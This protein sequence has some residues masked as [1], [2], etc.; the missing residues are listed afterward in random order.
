[1][2]WGRMDD[3]FDDHPK[4]VAM[5]DRDDPAEAGVAI[6]LWALAFSWVNRNTRKPGKI[7]GLVPAGLPRRWLGAAG[8]PAADLLVEHGLWE[9]HESGGW[10]FHDFGDYLPS[11]S[12]RE[13]RSEAGR[14][15]AEARWGKRQDA[16]DAGV[17]PTS[18]DN[19]PSGCHADHGNEPCGCHDVATA[20]MA[21]DGSRAGARRDPNP[22]PIP[23]DPFSA[24]PPDDAPKNDHDEETAPPPDKP[25]KPAGKRGTRLPDDFTVTEDMVDWARRE[26]PNVGAKATDEFVDYW[27]AA[28]GQKGVKLDWVATWRNWMR[29]AQRD[30]EAQ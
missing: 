12:T 25:K 14:R 13:A 30:Y 27:R 9:V 16:Q 21:T 17:A 2:G 24:S 20:A 6:G 10:L 26:T 15:G 1:M 7:P 29:K 3:G 11:E 23:I 18:D 5:L 4:V 22:N 8:R 19:L 28:P